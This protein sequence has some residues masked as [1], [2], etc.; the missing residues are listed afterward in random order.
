[1]I[2][3]EKVAPVQRRKDVPLGTAVHN[4]E[5]IPGRGGQ[6]VARS[7]GQQAIS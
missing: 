2:A 7:A 3:G 5:I 1:M 4:V 6:V